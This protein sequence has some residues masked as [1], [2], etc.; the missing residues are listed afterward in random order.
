MVRYLVVILHIRLSSCKYQDMAYKGLTR[1]LA[2]GWR[3]CVTFTP[4]PL[5]L[6]YRPQLLLW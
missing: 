3:S 2:R 4:P 1:T 6:P 5:Q